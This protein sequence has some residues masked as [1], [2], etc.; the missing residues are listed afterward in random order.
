MFGLC[1]NTKDKDCFFEHSEADNERVEFACADGS[2][3]R[4]TAGESHNRNL[5]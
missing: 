5:L 2:K 4:W 1:P 3:W